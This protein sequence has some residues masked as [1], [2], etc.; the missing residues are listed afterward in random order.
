MSLIGSVFRQTSRSLRNERPGRD[1]RDGGLTGVKAIGT[2][3]L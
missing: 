3:R 2:A 1:G